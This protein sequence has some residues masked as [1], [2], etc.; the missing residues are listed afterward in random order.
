MNIEQEA[1]IREWILRNSFVKEEKWIEGKSEF[2]S[3]DEDKLWDVDEESYQM[4]KFLMHCIDAE[5][6]SHEGLILYNDARSLCS[7]IDELCEM[8]LYATPENWENPNK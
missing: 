4:K 3:S 1:Y 6:L 7:Y 2:S 5:S 8:M